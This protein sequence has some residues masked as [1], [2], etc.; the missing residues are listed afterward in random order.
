MG[1]NT[2]KKNKGT[3]SSKPLQ[4]TAG[5]ADAEMSPSILDILYPPF[6]TQEWERIIGG[7]TIPRV[8]SEEGRLKAFGSEDEMQSWAHGAFLSG[9]E[10]DLHTQIWDDLSHNIQIFVRYVFP[11]KCMWH[12]VDDSVKTQLLAI[13][14][15]AA[16]FCEDPESRGCWWLFGAWIWRILYDN[17]FSLACTDKWAGA[18]WAAFGCLVKSL[19]EK[20]EIA[21]NAKTYTYHVG[22][23][24][25]ARIIY[26]H[27]GPHTY[28]ERLKRII[29]KTIMPIARLCDHKEN[30]VALPELPP[31]YKPKQQKRTFEHALDDMVKDAIEADFSIVASPH[32]TRIEMHN[33]E[34]GSNHGFIFEYG[35][36]MEAHFPPHNQDNGIPVDFILRPMLR[37]YGQ[38]KYLHL[39]SR[40]D[41]HYQP[42]LAYDF[43]HC[44]RTKPMEVLVNHFAHRDQDQTAETR[45]TEP[46]DD[47]PDKDDPDD[48]EPDD[49]EPDDDDDD[50]PG[51]VGKGSKQQ[52]RSKRW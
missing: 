28:P 23:H 50:Y 43:G 26:L 49:D 18:D 20:M 24:H 51:S 40:G 7:N 41:P 27:H 22:R 35:A 14:P 36:S 21:S 3:A 25:M 19:G 4:P 38:L 33:P 32:D 9:S 13:S 8:L 1:R 52:P 6:P 2:R 16:E 42:N 46:G 15:R 17:L 47:E 5:E 48:D 34:T 11:P 29:L 44:A 30:R 31:N 39:P 10:Y 12:L 45:E 37:T